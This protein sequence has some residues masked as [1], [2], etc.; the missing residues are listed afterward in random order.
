MKFGYDN[1]GKL[2]PIEQLKLAE[3]ISGLDAK[4]DAL[5]PEAVRVGI[6]GLRTLFADSGETMTQEDE[7]VFASWEEGIL[8]FRNVEDHFGKRLQQAVLLKYASGS[9]EA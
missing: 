8:D 3:A 6:E 5:E 4:L 9:S 1:D 2:V 7:S